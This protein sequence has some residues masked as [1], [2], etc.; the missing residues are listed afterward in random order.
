[1]SLN[2]V[3]E[4]QII[5]SNIY[6][7]STDH[8]GADDLCFNSFDP[9]FNYIQNQS[10]IVL[11]DLSNNINHIWTNFNYLLDAVI[12]IYDFINKEEI[13]DNI[14]NYKM[15]RSKLLINSFYSNNLKFKIDITYDSYLYPSKYIDRIVLDL[16]IPDYIPPTLL[17]NKQDLSFSQALSTSGSIDDL[18]EILIADIS[19]IEI[20]QYQYSNQTEYQNQNDDVSF[21]NTSIIYNDMSHNIYGNI[22]LSNNTYS[23]IDIDVRNL[24][25]GTAIFTDDVAEIEIYYTVTDNANNSNRITRKV[26]VE[27]NL[28]YPN[29]FIN[30]IPYEQFILSLGENR[31][32]YREKQGITIKNSSI[33]KGITALDTANSNRPLE[34][35]VINTLKNTDTIGVYEN[36]ITLTATSETGI[37]IS[38]TIYRD[39][40]VI[41]NDGV[42]IGP[43]I[44]PNCPC[45]VYYKKIQHNYKLGSDGSTVK[46]LAKVILHRR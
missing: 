3:L 44:N 18:I 26:F 8:I 42:D 22:I 25:N 1:V 16:A 36:A 32:V 23:T 14:M 43:D 5:Y 39:I 17:F 38:T 19:F 10:N 13:Y 20:N 27:S 41:I 29:F 40:A 12:S 9:E 31:W 21:E 30:G 28:K 24:Y 7:H 6:I 46:R 34:I 4:N 33:L 15:S 37:S 35:K 11:V 2:E 45:P